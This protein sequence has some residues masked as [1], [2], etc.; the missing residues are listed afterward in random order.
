MIGDGVDVLV[1]RVLAASEG[2]PAG[3]VPRAA[4]LRIFRVRY[5]ERLFERGR[6]Y[7]GVVEGL[8][9]LAARGIHL[10]CVTNK[11]SEFTLPLLESARLRR[12]FGFIGCADSREKR[13]PA[14][15][16]LRDA[17][18]HFAVRPSDALYVGD[19]ALD[20]ATARAARCPVAVVDYGYHGSAELAADWVLASITDLLSTRIWDAD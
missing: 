20:I 12:F 7:P 3:P 15:T 17:F 2:G 16:L 8:T 9:G 5:R 14:P 13:K 4:A 11:H 10:G 19:S 6:V 18:A 1:E